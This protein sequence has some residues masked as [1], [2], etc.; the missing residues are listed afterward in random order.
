MAAPGLLTPE[1]L[2]DLKKEKLRLGRRR[3][4]VLSKLTGSQSDPA[5]I[6]YFAIKFRLR[7]ISHLI[8]QHNRAKIL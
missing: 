3:R 8:A 5:Y 7:A 6:E 4:E 2:V 1:E